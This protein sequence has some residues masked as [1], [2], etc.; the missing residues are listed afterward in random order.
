[1][2]TPG[3]RRSKNWT[4]EPFDEGSLKRQAPLTQ[5]DVPPSQ[6]EQ[7]SPSCTGGTREQEEEAEGWIYIRRMGDEVDDLSSTRCL[8]LRWY[9]SRR[10]GIACGF[11]QIHSHRTA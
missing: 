6:G 5:I 8:D 9:V 2:R 11:S 4:V 1:M 10:A 3:L 7:F